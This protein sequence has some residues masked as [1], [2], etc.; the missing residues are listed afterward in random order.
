MALK[1]LS[2]LLII[3]KKMLLGKQIRISDDKK[4]KE[5]FPDYET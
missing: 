5:T 2:Q 4:L 1:I 3:E